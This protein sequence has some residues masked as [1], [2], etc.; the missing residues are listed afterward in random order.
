VA[1]PV[2]LMPTISVKSRSSPVEGDETTGDEVPGDEAIG[3][4]TEAPEGEDGAD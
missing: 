4:V 2:G 1:R 3:E